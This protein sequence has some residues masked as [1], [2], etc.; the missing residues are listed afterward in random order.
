MKIFK[1]VLATVAFS[2]LL[3]VGGCSKD[4]V[5]F[6]NEFADEICKC[7]DADCAKK[8]SEKFE[9]QA[10]DMGEPTEAEKKAMEPAMKKMMECM[11]KASGLGDM[12]KGA[13]VK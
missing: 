4:K 13:D 7:K 10:K 8:V 12:G 2:S 11:L 3:A 1:L 9:K 6:M 5:K